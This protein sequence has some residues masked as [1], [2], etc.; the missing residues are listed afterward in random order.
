MKPWELEGLSLRDRKDCLDALDWW[1][2]QQDSKTLSG[3]PPGKEK[4]EL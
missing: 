1:L 4:R 3:L 2:E